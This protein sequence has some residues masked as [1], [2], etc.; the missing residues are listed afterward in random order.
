MVFEAPHYPPATWGDLVVEGVR[1]PLV[2]MFPPTPLVT[3]LSGA[4][5]GRLFPNRSPPGGFMLSGFSGS[6]LTGFPWLT[7]AT[8]ASW[9]CDSPAPLACVP[10]WVGTGRVA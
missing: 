1:L 8:L 7:S 6:P 10:Y 4:L 9:V 5:D 3:C 2:D